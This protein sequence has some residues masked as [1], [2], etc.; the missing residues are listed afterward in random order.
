MAPQLP[1]A[2]RPPEH[3]RIHTEDSASE[4]D[5]ETLKWTQREG[6]VCFDQLLHAKLPGAYLGTH[7]APRTS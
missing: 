2:Q 7:Q 1:A 6:E 5:S 3:L 4:K